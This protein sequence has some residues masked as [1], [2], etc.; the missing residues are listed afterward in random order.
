MPDLQKV[1]FRAIPPFYY[2]LPVPAP[3]LGTVSGNVLGLWGD[4][5]KFRYIVKL[6]CIRLSRQVLI[7]KFSVRI[8]Y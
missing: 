2:A 3:D 5:G 7:F 1:A 8:G 6:F 4:E